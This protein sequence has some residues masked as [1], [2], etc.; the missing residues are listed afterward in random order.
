MSALTIKLFRDLRRLW[1]Q[2]AAIAL[3]LAAGVATLVLSTGAY[4]SLTATRASYY[5][6]NRFADIFASATRA[7]KDAAV[8][9]A[10][11]D[12]VAAVESRV[13]GFGIADLEDMVEPATLRLVSLPDYHEAD[14]NRIVLRQGTLPDADTDGDALISEGFGKAHGLLPGHSFTGIVNGMRRNFRVTGWA[15]SPE[16]I[17]SIGPGELMPDERRYGIIW[18]REKQLSADFRQRGA[19]NDLEVKLVTGANEQA[20][21]EKI[22]AI[23]KAYGGRGAY[24]RKY[25]VSHAFLDAE[26]TQLR[27]MQKFLPPIFLLV[28]AFLVNMTLSRL[29]TLER[30][31]IG[32]LKAMGYTSRSVA[33]H[34]VMFVSV[35]ALCGGV[36]GM[37]AGWWLGNGMAL[38]YARFFKFPT[39]LFSR[40]PQIYAIAI[41]VSVGAAVA[42]AAR[43]AYA[44]ARLSPVVA[45][46]PPA[47]P[48]YRQTM[49]SRNGLLSHMPQPAIMNLR[50]LAHWPWRTLSGIIGVA[51]AVSILV[52]SLWSKGALEHMID[53]SFNRMERQDATIHFPEPLNYGAFLS[54]ARMRGIKQAEPF[55]SEDVEITFKNR[56]RRI[57]LMGKPAATQL[58]RLLDQNLEEVT[59]PPHGVMLT[60]TLADI[61]GVTHG[62]T[63]SLIFLNRGRE[64]VEVPVSAI[65]QG[66]F[67]LGAFIDLDTLNTLLHQENLVSGVNISFDSAQRSGLLATLKQTPATRFIVF[68]KLVQQRFKETIAENITI[69]MTV[70]VSLAGIVAFGV[71]YNFARVSLSEQGREL[72]SLRVIG[73]TRAE[74]SSF[75]LSE[76]A[77]IVIIAQPIGWLLG[78]GL[79]NA[80]VN[81]FSSELYRIPLV[82]DRNVYAYAS[83]VVIAA[84]VISAIIVRR[85]IDG[86]D[87]VA[88]LKTRE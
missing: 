62:E 75:L 79:A 77:I 4:E 42:G 56:S 20:V 5:A 41:A 3:V 15:I 44:A 76:L 81:S 23:L 46:A 2:A 1:A 18:Q 43:A 57:G 73:F 27:A 83:L 66:Y 28:A 74:V 85:R 14:L 58:T 84:A 36:I 49:R 60:E 7:P 31:Q 10:D 13:A 69:M 59:L 61:L 54:V 11:I 16:F 9:I 82:M 35:I 52:G 32:L 29:I 40:D 51:L 12:G 64:T 67:G 87:M 88:V 71:I 86:L 33:L 80:V 19:F 26:L 65:T 63:V 24:G 70:Y 50:H 45:M 48:A 8:A 34:Y 78:T 22:D 39:L 21:I 25:H 6:E 17:Y 37:I 38:L 30:E 72:A 53:I 47:P 55:R 68:Q